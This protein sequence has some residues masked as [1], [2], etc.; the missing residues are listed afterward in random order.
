MRA[1]RGATGLAGVIAI[2][3]PRGLTSHDVVDRMRRATGERRIGHAG[4]LDPMATGLLL[5][6]VGRATRLERY[7]VGHDKRYEARIVFGSTTDT[8]DADGVVTD[9][10]PVPEVLLDREAAQALLRSF[11]GQSEQMPPA[12]SAIKRDGVPAY[13]LARAGGE[14]ELEPRPVE[15]SEAVVREVDAAAATWDCVFTVSSGTY[16]RSLARDIGVAGG[17]LAHLGALQRT[18]IGKTDVGDAWSLDEATSLAEAGKFASLLTDP[19]TLLEFPEVSVDPSATRDG[20]P[21]PYD[22]ELRDGTTVAL[23]AG[24]TLLGIYVLRGGSLAAETVFSPGVPR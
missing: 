3:K 11:L 10:M 13:R 20:R 6:L 8:L 12:Y 19:V 2:D 23:T 5:V 17:T 16:I 22:G 9:T 15:I 14:P 7:L 24:E 4:T 21:V 1:R 18:R